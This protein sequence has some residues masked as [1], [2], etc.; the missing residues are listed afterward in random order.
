M[1][2]INSGSTESIINELGLGKTEVDKKSTELGQDEF[3]KLMIAQLKN[4]DPF[5]PLENGD[6][7]AQMAQFS[8][9]SGLQQLQTSFDSLATSMQ[10]SQALQA[11]TL[12][13]RDVVVPTDSFKFDGVTQVNGFIRLPY[14][15]QNTTLRLSNSAGELVREIN[16]G[17]QSSGDLLFS[18]DGTNGKNEVLPVGEY[19]MTAE[20]SDRDTLTALPTFLF[21]KVD[22][23]T[24]DQQS[25]GVTLNLKDQASVLLS[26]V[27]EI[28]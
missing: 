12:V 6:F 23:V 15:S 3:L 7:I 19:T 28:R 16:V 13:G 17:A 22:S 20:A 9:V 11:S 25:R 21:A 10:S 8:S 1:N 26:E 24:L 2:T 18:W 5:K 4:Q 27:E 14:N